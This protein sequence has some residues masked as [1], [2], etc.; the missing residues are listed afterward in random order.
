MRVLA[1]WVQVSLFP[2]R[3]PE[4]GQVP[5]SQDTEVGQIPHREDPEVS[6]ALQAVFDAGRACA[7]EPVH[8][9][10]PDTRLLS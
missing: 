6:K 1:C 2:A 7:G 9:A 4:P 5:P 3:G 8:P 10:Q